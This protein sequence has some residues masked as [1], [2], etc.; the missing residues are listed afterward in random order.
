MLLIVRVIT[1]KITE[2]IRHS[3]VT[4]NDNETSNGI[5]N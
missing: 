1:M 3:N 2:I 4:Q 5:I